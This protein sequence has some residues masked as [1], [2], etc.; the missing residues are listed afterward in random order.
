MTSYI[1]TKSVGR[2]VVVGLLVS[3]VWGADDAKKNTRGEITV[4]VVDGSGAPQAN[5]TVELF[6]FDRD[7]RYWKKAGRVI[8]CDSKGSATCGELPNESAIII[9]VTAGHNLLG[10]RE[11][12]LTDETSRQEATVKVEPQAATAI[13][14]YDEKGN[15]IEGAG[16]W[17]IDHSGQNGSIRIDWRSISEF[18][19]TANAS[20]PDGE[21]QLPALPPGKFGVRV[22]H[23]DFAPIELK[24][25]EV[26]KKAT[27]R[28]DMNRGVK[29]T[30]QLEM[31]G[32]ERSLD[33]VMIDC[34]H[35]KFENP[36]TLIGQLRAVAGTKR[37]EVTVAPGGY[38]QI[39]VTHPE[40]TITPY[41]L[42]R[43]GH[44]L[45]D[46]REPIDIR[47]GSN[48]FAFKVSPKVKVHGRVTNLETGQPVVEE[49][50]KEVC[51]SNATL[52]PRAVLPMNGPTLV[53][54]TPT[55]VA[56]TNYTWLRVGHECRS[57]AKGSWPF[58]TTSTWMWPRTVARWCQSLKYG[59]CQKSEALCWMRMANQRQKPSYVFL[60]RD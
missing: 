28:A 26:G 48:V 49:R 47:E 36:S 10:Y 51:M 12:T 23:P 54:E 33:A 30:L 2:I 11:F 37:V 35:E 59:Q 13:R 52:D 15:A 45:A 56:T 60:V 57:K 53:G 17:Q 4:H 6:E 19:L 24:D 34:R 21:L 14:V 43:Y 1:T 3:R 58:R 9:R 18:G 44:T 8:R 46:H 32:D 22:V 55:R 27:A 16:I 40:Y 39:R 42:E 50:S 25:I 41:Y 5:A 29:L 20:N 38:E 31:A 7:W